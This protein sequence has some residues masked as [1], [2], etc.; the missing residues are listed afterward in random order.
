MDHIDDND[1]ID[2]STVE[3]INNVLPSDTKEKKNDLLPT[4]HGSSTLQTA[5]KA[6]CFEYK[7]IFSSTLTATPARVNPLVLNVDETKW[8]T[9]KNRAPAR[10]QT[11]IKSQ[12]VY[13]QIQKMLKAGI[14]RHNSSLPG[15]SL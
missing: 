9:K 15:R 10:L 1:Y 2:Q 4:I 13:D 5:L 6:L 8:L 3:D 7:D 12:E 14:I 11:P